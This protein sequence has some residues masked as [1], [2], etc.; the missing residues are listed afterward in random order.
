MPTWERATSPPKWNDIAGFNA[1]H[2]CL[3]R[4]LQPSCHVG[5]N[6]S[7]YQHLL[8]RFNII[9]SIAHLTAA[10]AAENGM[11]Q[12]L[13]LDVSTKRLEPSQKVKFPLFIIVSALA[14]T[15]SRGCSGMAATEASAPHGWA[16]VDGQEPSDGVTGLLHSCSCL[17]TPFAAPLCRPIDASSVPCRP[18]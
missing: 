9:L 18:S 8:H 12:R 16:N 1:L 11:F 10:D 7:H 5:L 13:A 6:I 14:S 2:L 17:Q 15:L 4:I 3:N